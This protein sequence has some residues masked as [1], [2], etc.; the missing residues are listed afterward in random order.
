MALHYAAWRAPGKD[1]VESWGPDWRGCKWY[2]ACL[3]RR[4]KG[5]DPWTPTLLPSLGLRPE[6]CHAED[7]QIAGCPTA[8]PAREWSALRLWG[9]WRRVGGLPGLGSLLDQ[10]AWLLDTFA[11]LDAEDSLIQAHHA[12]RAAK[13]RPE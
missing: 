8:I 5:A 7:R 6:G 13:R 3:G 11:V 10:D 4:C 9:I 12:E 1:E 2:G